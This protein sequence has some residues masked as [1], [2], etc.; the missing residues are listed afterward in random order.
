MKNIT[1][2]NGSPYFLNGEQL[3]EFIQ[4]FPKVTN[5]SFDTLPGYGQYHNWTK[6]S[7]FWD[8]PYWKHN[9]LRHN[10]DVMHIEKKL[11]MC[12]ILSWRSKVKQK[13]IIRQKWMLLN[14][15]YV[16][17]YSWFNYKMGS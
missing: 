11:I 14:Y 15:V 6:R 2:L 9:L 12:S 1:E 16:G 13:T 4:D 3:W 17:T 8:L 10:L 5:G 7:I